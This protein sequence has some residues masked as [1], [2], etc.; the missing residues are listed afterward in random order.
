MESKYLELPN[1]QLVSKCDVVGLVIRPARTVES[2]N[3]AYPACVVV[4]YGKGGAHTLCVECETN[5]EAETLIQRLK[6]D[7]LSYSAAN[8][9]RTAL[10]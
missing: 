5:L 10:P 7:L 1:G 2:L 3:K 9:N 6:G 8:S 4:N